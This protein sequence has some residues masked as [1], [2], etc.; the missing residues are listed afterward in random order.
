MTK[1]RT[2]DIIKLDQKKASKA[3]T[4]EAAVTGDAID[5]DGKV[6]A[7]CVA[8]ACNFQG[9]NPQNKAAVGVCATCGNFEHF[10]CVKIKADHKDDIVKGVQKYTCSSCFSKNP[11]VIS[12]LVN[13]QTK[14]RLRL[15]SLPLMGH[16]SLLR[17]SQSVSATPVPNDSNLEMKNCEICDYM[18]NSIQD[19]IKHMETTHKPKCDKCALVFETSEDLT[20][21][22][23][24]EHNILCKICDKN[25]GDK[26]SLEEHKKD[27][28]SHVCQICDNIFC[29]EKE[30]NEH[31]DAQ[32][33]FPCQVCDQKFDNKSAIEKH[34]NTSHK[35]HCSTKNSEYNNQE[36]LTKHLETEHTAIRH[37]C[38][39]CSKDFPNNEELNMHLINNH[40]HQCPSCTQYFHTEKDVQ[41]HMKTD[42]SYKCDHCDKVFLDGKS[43]EV[44][45]N[46][47]HMFQCKH[48][49]SVQTSSEALET[50]NKEVHTFLCIPCNIP[51]L[52]E[53]AS[54][55]HKETM[56]S[57]IDVEPTLNNKTSNFIEHMEEHMQ[58]CG[59]CNNNFKT[60]GLLKEHM[61]KT[62]TLHCEHC[63]TEIPNYEDLKKHIENQHMYDCEMCD[64]TG[65]G[66]ETME[67][68]ILE[69][70]A[71]PDKDG[72]YTCDD[73]PFQSRD[74]SS[75][76][77]HHKDN[78]GSKS[79]NQNLNKK[80]AQVE[81]LENELRQLKNNM[82]RLETMY[83][84]ALEEANNI[85][86]EYEAKLVIA[87]D[88]LTMVKKENEVLTEKVDI[89]F[90]LGRSYLD[91]T[92]NTNKDENQDNKNEVI[93]IND[94]QTDVDMESLEVWTTKKLRGFKR[95]NPS[96]NAEKSVKT[97]LQS[98]SPRKQRPSPPPSPRSIR[99]GPIASTTTPPATS[100]A[101]P[102]AE[103][104]QSEKRNLESQNKYCH[105]FVNMGRCN[106]EERTGNQCKFLHRPAP[107]CRSGLTCSRLKCMFSH[108]RINGSN[109]N[110]LGN[111]RPYPSSMNNMQL[112]TMINPWII[113]LQNQFMSNPWNN[114]NQHQNIWSQDRRNQ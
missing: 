60:R 89:L 107:M 19:M 50:H 33:R 24:I 97:N 47:Q 31:N 62:H 98:N 110:F 102:E 37:H 5:F 67:D 13:K 38:N 104:T 70:H 109:N 57:V 49:Q 111:T 78:H 56:H 44:H 26:R 86:S 76:G 96:V 1:A 28:H 45:K 54:N 20:Q 11:S 84:E 18:T 15:D 73:C 34:M 51:F 90:K 3:N 43:M 74:K 10:A 48:C 99:P 95:V 46:E 35:V 6:D 39:H 59:I 81:R 85:K 92:T 2:L 93:E 30:L 29:T 42:H 103:N 25:F 12:P 68:H 36:D 40:R 52:T 32:H 63:L 113:P 72:M 69:K 100:P 66:E 88:T 75:F 41:D 53:E 23:D 17:I 83:H 21:H 87:N 94:D 106:F 114:Q 64:Y 91:K 79:L 82:G 8:K 7:K 61:S 101:A 77:K 71:Q 27:T 16:G 65:T 14:P 9:L 4:N 58:E 108:P 55:S 80:S 105:Y 22:I 112:G